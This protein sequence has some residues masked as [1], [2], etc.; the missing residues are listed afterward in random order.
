MFYKPK[1]IKNKLKFL[2]KNRLECI[3]CDSL[4]CFC[5]NKIYKTENSVRAFE[6]TLFHTRIFG[7]RVDLNGKIL[8]MRE[9]VFIIIVEMIEKWICIMILLNM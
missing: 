3:F 5:D 6:G 8:L 1:C 9:I 7:R 4:L 2:R